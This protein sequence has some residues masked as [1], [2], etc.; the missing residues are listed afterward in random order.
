[1]QSSVP[2]ADVIGMGAS[3]ERLKH[4]MG[5]RLVIVTTLL[6]TAA[7]VEAVSHDLLEV[8]PLYILIGVTYAMTV[9][10]A[11]GLVLL[12]YRVQVYAQV[13]GDLLM[14]TGLVYLTGGIRTGFILL[15]PLSTLSGSVLLHRGRGVSFAALA[16]AFYA[17]VLTLVR[18][19]KIPPQGLSDVLFLSSQHL[20]YSV[21]VTGVTCV[22][23]AMTGSY[24]SQRLSSVGQRLERASEQVADLQ[25]F[26]RLVVESLQSGLVISDATGRIRSINEFGARLLGLPQERVRGRQLEE[27]FGPRFLDARGLELRVSVRDLARLETTYPRPDGA[28]LDLGIS[29]CRLAT[30]GDPGFL[31]VFQDLTRI[32]GLEE[33]VRLK[34]KLAA[35][36]EVAAH[37]AHEIRN[38]L[39][40]IS[41]SAQVLMSEP[42]LSASQERL[43]V[44][45]RKESRR[46]SDTLE[47]LLMQA[48][49]PSPRLRPLD[50]G[51]VVAEA[52]T[53]LRNAPE[54]GPKH[55]VEADSDGGTHLCMADRDQVLQVFWNLA[56]N[57]LEAMP[58]GGTLRVGLRSTST[59]V[60]LSIRD[61]GR[62]MGSEEQQQVFEPFHSGSSI[63][64]G[65]GLAIVYRIVKAHSGD[66][67][68]RSVRGEGT[69]VE[70][71]LP[72]VSAAAP[73]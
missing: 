72:A 70:V 28:T 34:E 50:L 41:G 55:T 56:R 40:S 65:L 43:L 29:L 60:V 73:A 16:T 7:S 42:G 39:G 32:K 18:L 25:E 71:R 24:L 45:I 1:V 11:V 8:N 6:L 35:V 54:V 22:V 53:L 2:V 44:I 67:D 51:P 64:L 5:F 30:T 15:Y 59:E 9:L 33:E 13:I 12:P 69:E 17:A 66:I 31:L 23:V 62:G 27:I 57:G 52:V 36:G 46:L 10:H 63:G 4:L 38:P 49:S 47:Q 3:L 61:H 48:R 19:E 68:V 21:F 20:L 14:I 58:G 37:L 26:N